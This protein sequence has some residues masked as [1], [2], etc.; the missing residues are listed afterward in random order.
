MAPLLENLAVADIGCSE[1]LSISCE[2][3]NVLDSSYHL[4]NNRS[5]NVELDPIPRDFSLYQDLLIFP[6][7]AFENNAS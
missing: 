5:I 4:R 1:A 2:M 7:W 6:T 3:L